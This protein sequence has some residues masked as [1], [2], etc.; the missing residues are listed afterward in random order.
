M[1]IIKLHLFN[2]LS[3]ASSCV[4]KHGGGSVTVGLNNSKGF[5]SSWKAYGT[6]YGG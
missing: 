6:H 3:T 1:D 2:E 4:V 5:E